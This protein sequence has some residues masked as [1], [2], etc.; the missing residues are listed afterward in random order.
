MH[1]LSALSVYGEPWHA[2]VWP[3]AQSVSCAHVS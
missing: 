2:Q 1:V 3:L